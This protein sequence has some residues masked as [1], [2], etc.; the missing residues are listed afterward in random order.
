[1]LKAFLLAQ[2]FIDYLRV[3]SRFRPRRGR[4][5]TVGKRFS[6]PSQ[7]SAMSVQGVPRSEAVPAFA[8]CGRVAMRARSTDYTSWSDP[9]AS[10]VRAGTVDGSPPFPGRLE[11]NDQ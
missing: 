8:A 4:Y 9:A 5:R 11:E 6:C 3:L 7:W 10:H 2:R 1:M